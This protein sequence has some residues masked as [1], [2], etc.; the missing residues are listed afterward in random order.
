MPDKPSKL[1]HMV[2]HRARLRA[3][4]LE[5][6]LVEA[7]ALELFLI[8]VIPRRDVKPVARALLRQFGHIHRIIAAPMEELLRVPGVGE[9]TA[10][11]LK[12]LHDL[13]LR[14]Y[15][16]VLHDS[17]IFH[18][19]ATFENYAKS[20]FDSKTIEEFHVLYLDAGHRLLRDEIHSVG[21]ID[22]SAAYPREIVRR[23]LDTGATIIILMHNH[24]GGVTVFSE[25][26]LKTTAELNRMLA[27]MNITLHDHYLF[28]NGTLY[29]AKNMNYL[30]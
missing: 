30:K 16:A 26:D 22:W 23:A 18:N 25:D 29:S 19:W 3:K 4:F 28:A 1:Y 8:Y 10:I 12:L 9:N 20:L 6:K 5:T 27:A 7:E 14:N 11:F 15:N 17:P 24:P 13:T 21:T 2:G